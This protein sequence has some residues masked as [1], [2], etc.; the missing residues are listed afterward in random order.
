[1]R[2]KK[3][4]ERAEKQRIRKYGKTV[5]GKNINV[6]LLT[7]LISQGFEEEMAAEALK[8]SNND[9]DRSFTLLTTEPELLRVAINNSK[10][11]YIP[12]E[13]DILEI[14]T[15]GFSRAQAY[16]TLKMTRGDLQ[17]SVEKLLAGEGREEEPIPPTSTPA[18]DTNVPTT[19]PAPEND[20][21]NLEPQETEEEIQRKAQDQQLLREAEHELIEDVEEDPLIAYDIDLTDESQ[22]IEHYKAIINSF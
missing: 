11:P 5:A 21:M 15:M 22:Y 13:T 16:G 14:M 10:P 1:M 8:Q 9:P 20:P 4:S 3:K 6:E 19:T 18:P 2:R 17:V 12:Q 7:V